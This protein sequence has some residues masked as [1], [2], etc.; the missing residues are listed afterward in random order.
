MLFE[1][2]K[3]VSDIKHL[4]DLRNRFRVYKRQANLSQAAFNKPLASIYFGLG[5]ASLR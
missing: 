5:L 2:M 4:F 3:N 1:T